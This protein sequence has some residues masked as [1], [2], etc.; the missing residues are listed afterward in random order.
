MLF[1]SPAAEK[2]FLTMLFLGP[3]PPSPPLHLP[4]D[5]NFFSPLPYSKFVG[6]V[7][8]IVFLCQ[9]GC[10]SMCVCVCVVCVAVC[11]CK[12]VCVWMCVSEC[13]CVWVREGWKR[14]AVK[15]R[16]RTHTQKQKQASE[17]RRGSR[18]ISGSDRKR[19]IE[20]V[21]LLQMPGST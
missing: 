3:P 14:G 9:S 1:T 18:F 16:T 19:E 11:M 7:K 8:K 15:A 13:V 2:I 10:V 4:G 6:L 17:L 12:C 21:T 20:G 5:S